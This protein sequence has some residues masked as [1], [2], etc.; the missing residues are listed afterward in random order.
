METVDGLWRS[1][2][3][4][5]GEELEMGTNGLIVPQTPSAVA[6]WMARKRRE[7]PALLSVRAVLDP[8]SLI[9]VGMVASATSRLHGLP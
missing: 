5:Q 1:R 7:V 4:R 8:R 9:A 2:L 6:S 3:V